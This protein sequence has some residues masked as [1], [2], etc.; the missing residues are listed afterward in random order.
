MGHRDA[1]TS[2]SLL[3][4]TLSERNFQVAQEFTM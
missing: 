1:Y 2:M 4:K 3:L